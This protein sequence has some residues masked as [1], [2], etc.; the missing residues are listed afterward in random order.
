MDRAARNGCLLLVL[1]VF[2]VVIFVIGVRVWQSLDSPAR[3]A[4]GLESKAAALDREGRHEEALA[5]RDRASALREQAR[6]D[7]QPRLDEQERKQQDIAEWRR[8]GDGR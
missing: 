2:V 3:R 5:L 8:T 1:V 6:Q 4:D 7:K